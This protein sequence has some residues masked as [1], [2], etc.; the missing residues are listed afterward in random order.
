MW[1]R[2]ATSS[3][4]VS[5]LFAFAYLWFVENQSFSQA[6]QGNLVF[7]TLFFFLGIYTSSM[8][9][10]YGK[11]IKRRIGREK[12]Q[13][14]W[15]DPSKGY[16]FVERDKG[17]DLFIHFASVEIQDRKLLKESTRVS[18][19]VTDGLKGPQAKDLKII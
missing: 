4:L 12:G 5:F 17:G 19:V 3:L 8:L 10:V 7:L 18:F 15:F 14:K 13:I 11:Q 1:L 9:I 2:G 6:F 16:G